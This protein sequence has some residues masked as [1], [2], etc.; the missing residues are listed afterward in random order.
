M[1]K[2]QAVYRAK[3]KRRL[4]RGVLILLFLL[5]ATYT[6]TDLFSHETSVGHFSSVEGRNQYLEAY[7]QVMASITPPSVTHDIMTSWGSVRVYE[8]QSTDDTVSIPVVLLPGHSSGA[9][10]WQANISAFSESHTVYA[11]DALGDAGKSMQLVPLRAIDDVLAWIDQTLD[12]LSLNQVHI[13]G[14]SFGAGFAANYAKAYPE[15]VRTLTL[16]EPA[17]A[18]NYPSLSVLFWATV[19]TLEFLPESWRNHGLAAMTGEDVSSVATD[20]PLAKMISAATAHYIASLPTPP[21]LTENEL[22]ALAMPV[23]VALGGNSPI[24]TSKTEENARLI[25]HVTVRTWENSTHSLPMEVASELAV[26]LE[27]F[28]REH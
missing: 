10:M 9:P 20:D 22:S 23:Y 2:S 15:R 25:P 8:W 14:H 3:P 19:A 5:L 12:E 28:W 18:L 4:L 16:M 13:V 7:D 24:T 6:L 27:Q 26:E 1:R 21:T 11:L 17:F